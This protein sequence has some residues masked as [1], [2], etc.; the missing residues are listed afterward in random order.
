ME[1]QVNN[2]GTPIFSWGERTWDMLWGKNQPQKEKKIK[3]KVKEKHS[4]ICPHL[5]GTGIH[6]R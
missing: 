6:G 3:I 2:D 1:I 5:N 4:I